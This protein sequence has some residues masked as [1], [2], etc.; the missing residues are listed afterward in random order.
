MSVLSFF[1]Q[2]ASGSVDFKLAFKG[3]V[4]CKFAKVLVSESAGSHGEKV[5][6]FRQKGEPDYLDKTQIRLAAKLN[7]SFFYFI[8][9]LYFS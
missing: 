8:F 2:P 3:T 7:A 9:R 5:F 1:A 4:R 6:H